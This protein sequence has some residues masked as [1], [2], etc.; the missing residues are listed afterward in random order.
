MTKTEK[1]RM[2]QEHARA[3]QEATFEESKQILGEFTK[4][5]LAE[6]SKKVNK[7]RDEFYPRSRGANKRSNVRQWF[8]DDELEQILGVIRN[9]AIKRVFQ[10]M[11]FYCLRVSEVSHCEWLKGRRGGLLKVHQPK[12]NREEFLPVHGRTTEILEDYEEFCDYSTGYLQV[13]MAAIRQ[14]AAKTEKQGLDN[15]VAES[16]DGRN[17]YQF[18]THS[19]RRTSA[20]VFGRVVGA[21]SLKV[22]KWLRHSKSGDDSLRY[23]GYGEREW[24]DDLVSAFEPY[25]DLI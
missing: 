16:K 12:N 17:L 4:Q 24:R 6:I 22:K 18:G 19:F 2:T 7:V 15:V 9:P 1:P 8:Y 14:D 23:Y 21:D 13:C 5:E 20:T 3:F 10:L 11:F 25:Y